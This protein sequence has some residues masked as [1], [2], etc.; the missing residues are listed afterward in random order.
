[1]KEGN[2]SPHGGNA[3]SGRVVG[4]Q[5][6]AAPYQGGVFSS[7]GGSAS[8][9][10][11]IQFPERDSIISGRAMLSPEVVLYQGGK[12]CFQTGSVISRQR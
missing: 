10:K 8:T 5:T 2:Q 7:N 11:A 1:M 12:C 9:G 4:L 6:E 3:S